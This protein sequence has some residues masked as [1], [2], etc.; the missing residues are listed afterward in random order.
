MVKNVSLS[1]KKIVDFENKNLHTSSYEEVE[2]L[3]DC[4]EADTRRDSGPFGT[5][6]VGHLRPKVV[7]LSAAFGLSFS[8]RRK[9]VE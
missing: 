6:V 4:S 5:G 8:C 3:V 9:P 2:N 1:G 7:F